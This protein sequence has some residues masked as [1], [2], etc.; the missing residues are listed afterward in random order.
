[1]ID[2]R[3]KSERFGALSG[4][5]GLDIKGGGTID[6][7]GLGTCGQPTVIESGTLELG[8]QIGCVSTQSKGKSP[9]SGKR[10]KGLVTTTR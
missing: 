6:L 2:I 8:S 5:R 7:I 9:T 1:M 10:N 4:S 3:G